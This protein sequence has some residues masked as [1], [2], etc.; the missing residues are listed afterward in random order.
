[1]LARVLLSQTRRH[2]IIVKLLGI[3]YVVLA[4]NKIDLVDFDQTVFDE[5]SSS[6]VGFAAALGFKDIKAIPISA[7]SATTS[8]RAARARPGTRVSICLIIWRRSMSTMTGRP[9][10]FACRCNGSIGQIPI[11]AVLP[12]QLS[13]AA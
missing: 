4:V 10:R 8:R 3:R 7:R 13:A 6:F 11:F 5:I 2:A 12:G 9:N 1:M